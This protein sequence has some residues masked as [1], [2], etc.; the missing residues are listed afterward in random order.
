MSNKNK[1]NPFRLY[2]GYL[3]LVKPIEYEEDLQDY[4]DKILELKI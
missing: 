3:D 4:L 2:E 1:D